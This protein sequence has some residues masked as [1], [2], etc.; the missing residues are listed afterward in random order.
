MHNLHIISRFIRP[1]EGDVRQKFKW[2]SISH[3]MQLI[4]AL[5]FTNK[6]DPKMRMELCK[7][8]LCIT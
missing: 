2:D 8:N 7:T 3:N 1:K 5:D 6:Q 4:S